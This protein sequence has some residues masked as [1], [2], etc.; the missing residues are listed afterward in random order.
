MKRSV[1]WVTIPIILG[2]I[3]VLP[4]SQVLAQTP[5]DSTK[6]TPKA[7]TKIVEK[8]KV[9]VNSKITK[10]TLDDLKSEE[11]PA[12][13]LKK[14]ESI[15]NQE[16]PDKDFVNALNKTLG[17]KQVAKYKTLILEYTEKVYPWD[18]GLATIDVSKYPAEQQ[19]NYKVYVQKC[20]KCHT[21]ARS[22][23]APSKSPK[24]WKD[25]IDKMKKKKRA[26]LDAKSSKTILNFINYDASIRSKGLTKKKPQ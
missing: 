25:Y 5:K 4:F 14:L 11:V 8:P 13:V 7:S 6:E 12:D 22:V 15:K 2:L 26:G 3:F 21:L 9:S 24:E 17:E 1:L 23:N 18:K 10:Q 16:F 20:S 19:A